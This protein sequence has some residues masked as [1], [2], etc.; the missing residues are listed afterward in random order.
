[1]SPMVIILVSAQI[2]PNR[3]EIS[4]H[5]ATEAGRRRAADTLIALA[6]I[7]RSVK[8]CQVYPTPIAQR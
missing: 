8:W 6:P 3:Y 2:S 5:H 7:S 4:A 1:M